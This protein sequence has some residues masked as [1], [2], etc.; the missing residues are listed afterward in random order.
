MVSP[1]CASWLHHMP[2]RTLAPALGALATVALAAWGATRA[3]AN[4]TIGTTA[5]LNNLRMLGIDAVALDMG[6]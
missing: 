4:Q 6:N 3:D 5:R 2:P 1:A